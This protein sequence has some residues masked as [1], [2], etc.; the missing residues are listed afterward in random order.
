MNIKH[1]ITFSLFLFSLVLVG[2]CSEYRDIVQ[3]S[4]FKAFRVEVKAN[5]E[6][7]D[8]QSLSDLTIS[9]DNYYEDLHLQKELKDLTNIEMSDLIPGLYN[10]TIKGR[11]STINDE[12]FMLVGT[13]VNYP[14]ISDN[15]NISLDV[16]KSRLGDLVF[17]E[18]FYAG[19]PKNY[20]RNQFYEIYN[21]SNHIIYLD[22]M[23]FAHLTPGVATTKLPQWPES[24]ADKY[25]Y[26]ERVWRFPGEGKD[27]PLA[28]GEACVISQFAA[29]HKLPQYNPNSPVDCSASEFEFNMNN[30][31]FPDQPAEDM[32]HVFYDGREELGSIP[33][34]L[35]PVFGG[36]F[37]IFE[38]PERDNYDP[39]NNKELQTKDLSSSKSKIFAK[40]PIDYVLDAVECGHNETM[41]AAK[42]IPGILDSGMTWVGQTY[43]NLGV[44]RIKSGERADGTPIYQ[45]TNNSTD[46]FERGVVPLF[47]RHGAK[48]PAWNHTLN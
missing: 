44:T 1:Q 22:G 2:G 47:R 30:P 23:Y 39:V 33:Q 29:N 40:I 5:L 38:A 45:D 8:I 35:T 48:M 14:I 25:C 12:T 31:N 19:T 4:D 13:L 3:S 6:I 27:Y 15:Q 34:Y 24:D 21:N 37:V 32:I 11:A 42:R 10:V 20:F 7:D 43:N 46:D 9:F 17:S 36:A 41:M 26:A 28:P 16:K 18:I